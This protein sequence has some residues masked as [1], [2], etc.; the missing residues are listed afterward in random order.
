MSNL[1][2]LTEKIDRGAAGGHEFER[3]L[4]RLLLRDG[5]RHGYHYEPAGGPAGDWRGVD[6]LIREGLF[7]GL[8]A[9]V[10]VQ[11]KWLWGEP[12]FDSSQRGQVKDSIDQAVRLCPDLKHWVLITPHELSNADKDWFDGLGQ[13]LPFCPHHSGRYQIEV[14]LD[15]YPALLARYCPDAARHHPE[16]QGY[17]GADLRGWADQYCA[18]VALNHRS[19]RLLG[20]PPRIVER[21]EDSGDIALR[22]VFVPQS[23][24]PQ[25]GEEKSPRT[26]AQ[27]VQEP[28]S[29]AFSA[30][31]S[32]VGPNALQQPR[33]R[34]L[35][36]DPGCG[37]S[38]VLQFLAL[39]Y[40][41]QAQLAKGRVR[42]RVPLFISL[43]EFVRRQD[44]Q[45][46]FNFVDALVDHAHS[47]YQMRSAHPFFFESLLL[48][49]EAVV[50]LD[51]LDEVGHLVR[52]EKTAREIEAFHL[53]YPM[54]PIWVTSRLVGYAGNGR[55]K[56]DL[57]D[58]FAVAPFDVH[59]QRVFIGNWYAAQLPH[60]APAREERT[61]SLTAAIERAP[62]VKRLAPN[63]LL[64]TLMAL[65]H[66]YTGRLPQSRCQLYDMGVDMLLEHWQKVKT[67]EEPHP[68]QTRNIFV[69]DAKRWLADLALWMQQR[70]EAGKNEEARGL[71]AEP[72]MTQ[73]LLELRLAARRDENEPAAR[74]DVKVFLDYIRNR[75]GLLVRR[76][77]ISGH[78]QFAFVHLSFQEYLAAYQL[79]ED[80]SRSFRDHLEFFDRHLG[81]PA[82]EET[83][84][85][86]LYRLSQS[87][88]R[89]AFPDVL[90][91]H[92][93]QAGKGSGGQAAA[94][95]PPALWITLGRALRDDVNLAPGHG[96]RILAYL[97]AHWLLDSRAEAIPDPYGGFGPYLLLDRPAHPAFEGRFFQ[98]LEE[99]ALFSE[100]WQP[101]LAEQLEEGWASL[102]PDAAVAY[103]HLHARLLPLPD[104][105]AA[106]L[107]QRRDLEMLAPDLIALGLRQGS[108]CCLL[109]RPTLRQSAAALFSL[110]CA[111]LYLQTLSWAKAPSASTQPPEC[112][113]AASALLAAKALA[114]FASRA[115]FA[116][117]RRGNEAAGL[118]DRSGV[119]QVKHA[120]YRLDMPLAAARAHAVRFVSGSEP[121]PRAS[122]LMWR[123]SLREQF[124]ERWQRSWEDPRLI[125]W[126]ERFMAQHLAAFEVKTPACLGPAAAKFGLAFSGAFPR[127]LGWDFIRNTGMA[128]DHRSFTEPFVC[129]FGSNFG[130]DF[131]RDFVHGFGRVIVRVFLRLFVRLSD[132]IALHFRFK[133]FVGLFFRDVLPA[134]S[135]D[136]G[137]A[138][139]QD[140]SRAFGGDHGL[141]LCRAVGADPHQPN[142]QERWDQAMTQAENCRVTQVTNFWWPALRGQGDIEADAV[143]EGSELVVSLDNPLGLPPLMADL[144]SAA[145]F[146]YL[147]ALGRHLA[148]RSATP[149]SI[150]QAALTWLPRNPLEVFNVAL[151]WEEHAKEYAA[152]VGRLSGPSGALFLS[153]AAYAAL[154]TGLVGGQPDQP[155]WE[156]LVRERD[157]SDPLV[158]F[159]HLLYELCLFQ[160]NARVE[161]DMNEF[162]TACPRECH[163]VLEAAGFLKHG[164]PTVRFGS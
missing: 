93:A 23:F 108:A 116:A 102:P 46:R 8:V 85:L 105:A 68:L 149:E 150:I 52:R 84:L 160:D 43:G 144:W 96:R 36:G 141:S 34:V 77:E 152:A 9:P 71:L 22:Q 136:F 159:S 83:L 18:R 97:L 81:D 15:G 26:L 69:E 7:L 101:C 47:T 161:C 44:R 79:S 139:A 153:H 35:L 164:R 138:F 32:P 67:P 64:L 33:P 147:F 38:T 37:K 24:I 122:G 90:M 75:T 82:W 17:D 130:R 40:S 87:T 127:Q 113:N 125:A 133:D 20:L 1:P 53:E 30:D 78:D 114:E 142:W 137:G 28:D 99:I 120:L 132:L 66:R 70:N 76:G 48:M 6:G 39:L 135:Y 73:K 49:G 61:K 62:G 13:G 74:E 56:G 14:W 11:F 25:S 107:Q 95:Q 4:H 86:L 131:G 110:D 104:G 126:T 148:G 89:E 63:P 10:G 117:P 65:I 21:Q 162:L 31:P 42:N 123:P 72:E 55:L 129:A 145:A 91:E 111:E 140:V 154:M 103:L 151:A 156:R 121:T 41:G 57:F 59:Q 5:Q 27:L 155:T 29:D 54:C 109:E 3:L 115:V 2:P 60:D 134:V 58:D 100:R 80:R 112:L 118:F 51:G 143:A 158:Q 119:V 106:K 19:L 16:A 88:A 92:F 98:A 124:E 45:Q 163:A 12:T 146:N 128:F 94:S 157:Q 50:L